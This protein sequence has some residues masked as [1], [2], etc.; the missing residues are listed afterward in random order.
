MNPIRITALLGALALF[1][2]GCGDHDHGH[3]HPHAPAPAAGSGAGGAAPGA[4]DHPHEHSE[5]VLL[6]QVDLAGQAVSV[7]RMAP[8]VPGKEADFDL[9]FAAGLPAVV[10]CWI[11]V[12]SGQGSMKAR[13]EKETDRRMH[14]HPEVPSPLP[15]GAAIWLETEADGGARRVSLPL[16]R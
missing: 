7:Y 5:R 9:E 11:G 14:G 8:I 4:A 3:D 10:R 1:A 16:P 12:E 2:T 13:M 6:G 15:A